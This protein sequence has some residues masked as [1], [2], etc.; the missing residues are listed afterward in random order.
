MVKDERLR[1]AV[2]ALLTRDIAK[3]LAQAAKID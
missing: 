2:E 3:K 1:L